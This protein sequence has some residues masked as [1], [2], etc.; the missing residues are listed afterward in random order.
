M[1]VRLSLLKPH[2][3]CL[4]RRS[5]L[6]VIHIKAQNFRIVIFKFLI[7]NWL[8]DFDL[9]RLILQEIRLRE[10]CVTKLFRLLNL[11]LDRCHLPLLDCVLELMNVFSRF[12]LLRFDEAINDWLLL[13]YLRLVKVALLNKL[14]LFFLPVFSFFFKFTYFFQKLLVL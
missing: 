11:E 4:F 8:I 13:V 7:L 9:L 1:R 10:V 12:E 14:L 2:I 3:I 5:N 6:L